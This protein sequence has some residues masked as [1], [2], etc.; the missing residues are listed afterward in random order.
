[1]LDLPACLGAV[2]VCAAVYYGMKFG[3]SNGLR[4]ILMM[5]AAVITAFVSEAVYFKVTGSKDIKIEAD[6]MLTAHRSN[7]AAANALFGAEQSWKNRSFT[8][9]AEANA[10]GRA[11]CCLGT[12]GKQVDGLSLNTKYHVLAGTTFTLNGYTQTLNPST[13]TTPQTIRIFT[14]GR[15]GNADTS[16]LYLGRL[17]SLKIYNGST[18]VRNYEPRRRNSDNMVSLYDLVNDTFYLPDNGIPYV[19]GPVAEE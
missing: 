8:F 10:E 17:F 19:A 4:V 18:L 14:L 12:I 15:I 9:V 1:M 5:A 7:I 13:F 11:Y 16:A 2:T 6:Y 3:A